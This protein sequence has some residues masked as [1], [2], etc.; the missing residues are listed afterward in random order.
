MNKILS[1]REDS[2]SS[3]GTQ[4]LKSRVVF[5]KSMDVDDHYRPAESV[6][7]SSGEVAIELKEGNVA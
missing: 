5:R 3:T 6:Q 4:L 1:V 7:I 2:Y